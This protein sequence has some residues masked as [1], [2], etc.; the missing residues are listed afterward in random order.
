MACVQQPTNFVVIFFY[1]GVCGACDRC[2]N[3]DVNGPMSNALS[4]H[5]TPIVYR[6]R[7][8]AWHVGAIN[9]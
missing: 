8:A 3:C 1:Q 9:I 7:L 2:C 6:S 5:P 4:A